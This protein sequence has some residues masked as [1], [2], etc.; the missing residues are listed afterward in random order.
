M[1]IIHIYVNYVCTYMYCMCVYIMSMTGN[2]LALLKEV[3]QKLWSY[4]FVEMG[5]GTV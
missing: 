2:S 3:S 4:P 1:F 5:D